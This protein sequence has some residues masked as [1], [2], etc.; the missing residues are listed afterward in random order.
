MAHLT[1]SSI[2]LTKGACSGFSSLKVALRS[3]ALQ[4]RELSGAVPEAPVLPSEISQYY[5][6]VTVARPAAARTLL[7]QPRLYGGAE[8]VFLDK[9]KGKEYRRPYRLLVQP[10]NEALRWATAE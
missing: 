9:K 8:V 7:Y 6:P 3:D 4:A 2:V 1:S 10:A 5:I